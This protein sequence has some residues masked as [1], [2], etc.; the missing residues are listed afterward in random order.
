VVA[1][2][3]RWAETCFSARD[4]ASEQEIQALIHEAS[5]A[6]RDDYGVDS[7]NEW[8]GGYRFPEEYVNSD[9][10]FLQSQM[11]DFTSMVRR[12]LRSLA[13]DRLNNERVEGLRP[14]NPERTLLFELV[15][16]M[17]VHRPEGFTPN[18]S[19]PRTDL[20][21][22]YEAVAPAVNKML[23]AVV[24]QKLAFL[25]PLRVAQ[26]YVP[27]LHLCKAHWCTKKGKASGRP[28]GDLSYVDGTPLNTDETADAATRHY[29]KIV[30]PTINDIANMIYA[31]WTDAKSKNPELQ[32]SDL[33][34]WKMDLKGA[35]TL[36]SYRPEDVG[37]FGMLLTDDLVYLQIAG[38]FGWAGT[39]AAFQVVTRAISWEMKHALRSSTLMYVDD[40]IG[41]CFTHEVDEDL[42]AT[43]RICTSL[44]GPGA[45]ADDKTETGRRLDIIGYTVDLDNRR[46]S[47]AR[48]KFLAALHGFIGTDVKKRLNLRTAQRLASWGT[49][50]GKI[51]RVMRPFCGALNCLTWGRKDPYALFSLSAEATVA[52]QCWRAMLCL[53]RQQETEFTRTIESFVLTV[54]A[55]IAEFDSSLSGAGLIWY[56]V[57]DG[58]RGSGYGGG[59]RGG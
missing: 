2:V 59:Q 41:V 50:Y 6:A 10:K 8:A 27:E 11:L 37:L 54:P 38:I 24:E 15:G 43:R 34:I 14:D 49:R 52:V 21:S 44:L 25:L 57:E 30:H 51:C 55:V 5:E 23:G 47:I 45:V 56:A 9:V 16:G 3:R 40:I 18:G 12:R 22:A 26:Q 36:L 32:W 42:A 13:P 35:Y 39:P 1:D 33:R 53:V 7:A 46:V 17:K 19:L 28:L 4:P 58:V 29:G 48:K 31:F 20:R